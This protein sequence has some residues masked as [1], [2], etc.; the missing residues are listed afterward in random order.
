MQRECEEGRDNQAVAAI[1]AAAAVVAKRFQ[2]G[3]VDH[4]LATR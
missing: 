2:G 1:Q 3:G 4:A